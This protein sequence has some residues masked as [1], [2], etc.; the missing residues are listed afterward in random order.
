M[1]RKR[2]FL[3]LFFVL[4][5]GGGLFAV[6]KKAPEE[7]YEGFLN[8]VLSYPVSEEAAKQLTENISGSWEF[9]E[10]Q[11]RDNLHKVI[12]LKNQ[13]GISCVMDLHG[14]SD[15]SIRANSADI[16]YPISLGAADLEASSTVLWTDVK[17]IT[18]LFYGTG[19]EEEKLWQDFLQDAKREI[20]CEGNQWM[21]EEKEGDT[22][23][24][25]ILKRKSAQNPWQLQRAVLMTGQ[26]RKSEKQR[27]ADENAKRPGY[28][29]YQSICELD[30]VRSA[31]K[32][33][34][35]EFYGEAEGSV[36]DISYTDKMPEGLD[37]E[38]YRYFPSDQNG[39]RKGILQDSTGQM[40]VF[41]AP[42]VSL[43]DSA[44]RYQLRCLP[45]KEGTVLLIHEFDK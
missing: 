29:R 44:A 33:Q 8:K 30:E 42:G 24:K 10:Y 19:L 14:D 18:T 41:I 13:D 27:I 15:V 37:K 20:R 40:E 21:W 16:A 36:G 2:Q 5:L 12:H 39:Y 9:I 31:M 22:F 25:V 6:R 34:S 23:L 35:E 45:G 3:L 4:L 11:S 17:K 32:D 28:L 43:S 1:K 38:R 7:G 26:W